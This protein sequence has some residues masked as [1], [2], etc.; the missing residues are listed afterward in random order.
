MFGG[1]GLGNVDDHVKILAI[2]AGFKGLSAIAARRKKHVHR[3]PFAGHNGEGANGLGLREFILD[4]GLAA[5]FFGHRQ[6]DGFDQV[7]IAEQSGID[8]AAAAW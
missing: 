4:P 8:G 1:T 7:A 6:G 2:V 3:V 5:D